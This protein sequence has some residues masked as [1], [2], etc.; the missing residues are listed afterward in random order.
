MDLPPEGT[1]DQIRQYPKVLSLVAIS[2]IL[3]MLLGVIYDGVMDPCL[4]RPP[5]GYEMGRFLETYRQNFHHARSVH[6]KKREYSRRLQ[7]EDTS[8]HV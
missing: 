3:S 5:Q 4:V 1:D 2:V 6:N 8:N 7:Y